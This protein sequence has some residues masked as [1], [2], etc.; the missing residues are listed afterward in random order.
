MTETIRDPRRLLE[1]LDTFFGVRNGIKGDPKEGVNFTLETLTYMTS[2]NRADQITQMIVDRMKSIGNIPFPVFDA[3]AGIGGNTMS[4]LDNP[5]VQWVVS[6]ELRPERR[7]MLKRNI[8]MYNLTA[9]NRA[10]VPDG[11]FTGVPANYKN[12]VLYFDPPWLPENIKGHESTKEDYVLHGIKIG[13]E[14]GE[15]KTLEEWIAS[16]TNCAMVVA[17]VPPGYRLDNIPGFK[18]ESQ[19]LKNSL[20]L[21]VTPSGTVTP[22]GVKTVAGLPP[23]SITTKPVVEPKVIKVVD[24]PFVPQTEIVPS[25]IKGVNSN[26][27]E[28]YNGLKKYLYDLLAMIVPSETHRQKM[29]S[30]EAMKIWVPCFTHESYNQNVG[31]NYE[32]L[33]L[34]GDHAMEYNFVMYM[35]KNIP[36]IT[37]KGLSELKANYISKAFQAQ[38]GLKFKLADWVR[39]RVEKNTHIF[40]DLLE[41]FFGGINIVGDTV[42]KFGAGTG[43]CYNMIVK[44]FEDID[45]DMNK[46]RGKPKTQMKETFEQLSWG[47]PIEEFEKNENRVTTAKISLTPAAMA[48]LR[49]LGV[50]IK[51]PLIAIESGSSKHVAFDNAYEVALSNIRKMG[52]TDEWVQKMRGNRDLDN[53]NLKPYFEP[54]KRKTEAEGYSSFYMKKAQTTQEGKYIQLIGVKPDNTLVILTMT[55]GPRDEWDGKLEV[56]RKYIG[57]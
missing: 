54:V 3:T 42:F 14:K 26:E 31:M 41:S 56:L 7:D 1:H 40:E 28:W 34:V 39:I 52:I 47:K 22:I 10:F 46:A 29:I 13:D 27:M 15:S 24:K 19:L 5:A 33:E 51:S 17:R 25:E 53:P 30:D 18:V 38:I 6:Y 32:E 55:D 57:Q 48:T 23:L 21:F 11:P 8:A 45:I 37:R 20:V 44:I 43:L 50:N 49:S 4:F 36:N 12:I 16:C 35:Y 2:R 9:G